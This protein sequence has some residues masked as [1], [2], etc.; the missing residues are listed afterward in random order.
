MIHSEICSLFHSCAVI[1]QILTQFPHKIA[2]YVTE[3]KKTSTLSSAR[4][5]SDILARFGVVHILILS[6]DHAQ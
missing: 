6:F 2:K 5:S 1:F 3:S 4:S